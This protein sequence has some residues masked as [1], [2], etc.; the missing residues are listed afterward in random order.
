MFQNIIDV[1]P[2]IIAQPVEKILLT[3]SDIKALSDQG[4]PWV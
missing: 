4:T 3:D 1:R 2:R